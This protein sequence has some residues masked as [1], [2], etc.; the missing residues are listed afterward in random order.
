MITSDIIKDVLRSL[1]W[2]GVNFSVKC[3]DGS[4]K[5]SIRKSILYHKKVGIARG[6]CDPNLSIKFTQL[7]GAKDV[8]L[9]YNVNVVVAARA[10]SDRVKECATQ[11]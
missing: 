8:W 3:I 7:E 5:D 9:F 2:G 10:Q 4:T 1:S 11:Q 6:D